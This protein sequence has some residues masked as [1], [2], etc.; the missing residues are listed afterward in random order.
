MSGQQNPGGIFAPPS[1]VPKREWFR[2]AN[3]R[4]PEAADAE[5]SADVYIYDAIGGWFGV[6]AQSFVQQIGG[7][8]VD[9][10]NLYVNSPGGDV[11]DATAIMNALRRHSAKV[12]A[13]VDGLAASAASYIIQAADEVVMSPGSQLMIHDPWNMAMGNAEDMRAN[14]AYLDQLA[15]NI[16]AMYARRA[17]GEAEDW[18]TVMIAEQWYTADEAVAAKLAD[19][20]DGSDDAEAKAAANAF[21]LTA[22]AFAGR[23][24]AGPPVRMNALASLRQAGGYTRDEVVA[25]I[26]DHAPQN[27]PAAPAAGA[28]R[29]AVPG[30]TTRRESGMDPDKF[31][32]E[33][34]NRAGVPAD[35][36][37]D[38]AGVLA[39]LD[40]A[41]SEGTEAPAAS[42]TFTPPAGTE[43][44]ESGVLAELRRKAEDGAAARA[45]QVN[46]RRDQIVNDA[47]D[48]GRIAPAARATWRAALDE[49][50]DSTTNVLNTL[51]P[52]IVPTKATGYTGGVDEATDEDKT[53]AKFWGE[54]DDT[55]KED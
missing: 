28:N 44:V 46:E 47:I 55:T 14:A 9:T 11:Y 29:P 23:E 1:D 43:V 48:S 21:D 35:A 6:D 5:S 24:Q 8:D 34:R 37:L 10:I 13:T 50:E 12:V 22:F 32:Q 16:A 20:V 36:T 39:A 25:R 33:V 53:F 41:L 49:N 51:T 54:D 27:S 40:E 17:G 38:H 30:D 7:L 26:R 45:Q 19:R 52:G 2:V 18:R 42:T 15:D 4:R 31:L 3:V